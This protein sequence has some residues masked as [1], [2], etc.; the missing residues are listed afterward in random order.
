MALCLGCDR[1]MPNASEC[2]VEATVCLSCLVGREWVKPGVWVRNGRLASTGIG[3]IAEILDVHEAERLHTNLSEWLPESNY[4]V[5]RT[6]NGDM[7]QLSFGDFFG[8][9]EPCAPPPKPR[10]AWERLL[11]E[12]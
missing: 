11:G 7:L 1:E 4:V 10:T 12:D 8:T 3:C 2:A 6:S 9:W 5:L